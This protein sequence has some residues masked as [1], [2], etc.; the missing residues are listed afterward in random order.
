MVQRN[1]GVSSTCEYNKPSFVRITQQPD[2]VAP[3]LYSMKGP[4]Y[5]P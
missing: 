3:R 4:L 1:Q 5:E 2:L